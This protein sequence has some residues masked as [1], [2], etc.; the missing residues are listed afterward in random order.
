M[1]DLAD[2]LHPGPNLRVRLNFTPSS[3]CYSLLS[4]CNDDTARRALL[5]AL[6]EAA[7]AALTAGL[8]ETTQAQQILKFLGAN[9]TPGTTAGSLDQVTSRPISTAGSAAASAS[10]AARGDFPRLQP[11]AGGHA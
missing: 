4:A 1:N 11:G 7:A 5:K 2:L 3:P 6:C 9:A 8:R 10:G